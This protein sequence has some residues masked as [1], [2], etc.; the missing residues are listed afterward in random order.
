MKNSAYILLIAAIL[1]TVANPLKARDDS[2]HQAVLDM[3]PVGYW[4]LDEGEGTVARDLSSNKNDGK[5]YHVDWE[6]KL[7]DFRGAY[8]WIEIPANPAY[9]TNAFSIGGWVY[10]RSE[11]FGGGWPNRQGMLLIGNRDWLN[12]FGIQ[13]AIRREN[14]PEVVSSGVADLL[15]TRLWS[16]EERRSLSEI[17]LP[18]G[19]WQQLL[20]TFE[21]V[22]KEGHA[23]PTSVD[24]SRN[25]MV[26][27]SND[28]GHP[29]RAPENAVDGDA[30]TQWVVWRDD[31]K[32]ESEVW[33][34]IDFSEPIKINRIRLLGRDGNTDYFRNGKLIFSD[35]S[36]IDVEDFGGKWSAMF[37]RRTVDWIRFLSNDFVGHRP[38]LTSFEIYN[39]PANVL[40]EEDVLIDTGRSEGVTGT[41]ILYL[42]GELIAHAQDI[43]YN[44]VNRELLMGNDANWWHMSIRSGSLNGALRDMVW[45]DRVLDPLEVKHLYRITE[46]TVQPAPTS[47]DTGEKTKLREPCFLIEVIEDESKSDEDRAVAILELA[48]HIPLEDEYI[49]R[50]QVL[51]N[52][53]SSESGPPRIENVFRNAITYLLLKTDRDGEETQNLLGDHFAKPFLDSLDLTAEELDGVRSAYAEGNYMIALDRL[54]RSVPRSRQEYYFTHRR[55]E[56]RDYTAVAHFEDLTYKVGEGVAWRGV[57]PVNERDFE[58]IL[59]RLEK[60]YPN[61]REWRPKDFPHL[62]RVTLTRIAEDGSEETVYLGGEDFVLD[63]TDEKLRGW[64]IFVDQEGYIHLIGGQ[65]NIPNPDYY[66]PGSWE[67]MGA[68]R[69]R[70][71]SSFP[72][73]MYWVSAKPGS[74]DDFVFV[75]QRDNPRAIPA[76]Y[77]NYMVLLQDAENRTY[78]YGRVDSFGWQSWGMFAYDEG[79]RRWKVIGGEPYDIVQSIRDNDPE[80]FRFASHNIR[81]KVPDG[82]S[83]Q[84]PLAW[85]WQP[86]FY[87][88]CRDNWGARFDRTGRLHVHMQIFGLDSDGHNR[89]SS[90]YAWS[91][92]FGE[93]FHL[94][95][96]EQVKLPLTLNP[97]PDHNAD[98]SEGNAWEWW[99]IWTSLIREAGYDV[100]HFSF[101]RLAIRN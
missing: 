88:F 87:N 12:R 53:T 55:P 51:Y 11:V 65:H 43:P 26:T 57:E 41:G 24:L 47:R 20:Y 93:T 3:T 27:A 5:L 50:L 9:Q 18:I 21:P 59:T 94:A 81:G 76:D 73:I 35:G 8:Q 61:V 101:E 31:G 91:D 95:N 32:R 69:N 90:V 1:P 28:G 92:D 34:Q 58:E 68:S 14:V 74:L 15:E 71:S 54:R 49:R 99:K 10:L 37:Y 98:I 79:D 97:A 13:L 83:D 44:S 96:G 67:D 77:L 72:K 75:G 52:Q 80:W 63:G 48:K 7:T 45:F 66:I 42:N 78:L 39:E 38:G 62:Y 64:S 84:K 16:P 70:N 60:K 40:H 4:P 82:P 19:E 2:R 33:I 17:R 56:E 86:A 89:K 23:D 25:A 36:N 29:S 6:N 100:P 85:S 22:E 46:P 30:Q